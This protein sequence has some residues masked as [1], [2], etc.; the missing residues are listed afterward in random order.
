[1]KQTKHLYISLDFLS[2]LS[3]NERKSIIEL[4]RINKM[5]KDQLKRERVQSDWTR[6]H[7]LNS[8]QRKELIMSKVLR[9]Q[10]QLKRHKRVDV[11]TQFRK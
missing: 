9:A 3:Y 1:M 5:N 7:V 6:E 10:E 8:E 4:N 2:Q 11:E